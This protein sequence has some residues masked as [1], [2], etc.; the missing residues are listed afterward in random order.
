MPAISVLL[1]C[2]NA[3][4][5]L[6][7]ALT[8]LSGQTFQDYE[9]IAVD[10]GSSD[11]TPKVLREWSSRD[12]RI[13][14]LSTPHRGIVQALNYGLQFCRAP[15]VARMDADDRCHPERLAQQFN[16]LASH[17]DVSL[18]S[19][20]VAGFPEN[21]LR[22]GFQIYIEW[23]NGL[24]TNEDI[25]REIFIESPFPHPSVML[26][27]V[28]VLRAGSYSDRGWAED[29]DLWLRMYLLGMRFAKLPQCL[30]DWRERPDRLT[31][32]DSRYSLE[33]FLRAKAFY[34]SA[35]PLTGR[36]AVFIWGAGM[37]GKRLSKHLLRSNI[38]LIAFIDIDREKI[39]RKLRGLPIISAMALS[40]WLAGF[41]LPITLSAVGSRGARH[42]I[43]DFLTGLALKEGYDWLAVA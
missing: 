28:D 12:R 8:S 36:D 16:Y 13:K 37:T 7:E 33:N 22:E 24:I 42:K 32:T 9:I 27:R 2:Y 4:A 5:T 11:Q 23:L 41:R 31:R 34:L 39:G 43:R 15:V 30:L 29:Y 6:D 10:D 35:G 21:H 14:V 1:P 40:D 20:Q 26:R 38:P 19:C 3:S 25:C 17:P 18:V